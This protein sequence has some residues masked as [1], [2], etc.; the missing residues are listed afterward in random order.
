[1]KH[2]ARKLF[3]NWEKEEEWLN[4]MSE[5]G[6]AL[7]NHSWCR[8]EFEESPHGKYIYRIEILNEDATSPAGRKHIDRVEETGAQFVASN[9]KWVYFRKKAADGPFIL[10]PDCLS[11]IAHNKRV[12]AYNRQFAALELFVGL[13]I[14]IYA[15]FAKKSHEIQITILTLGGMPIILGGVFSSLVIRTTY[16]INKLK[17]GLIIR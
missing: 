2:V 12:R 3:W 16:K 5:K 1:M 6:L 4:K 7:V 13:I 9:T 8:Y 17:K 15:I 11:Q 10:H 14:V